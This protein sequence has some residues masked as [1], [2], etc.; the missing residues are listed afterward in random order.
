[1]KTRDSCHHVFADIRQF[2]RRKIAR[3]EALQGIGIG[4]ADAERFLFG[5]EAQKGAIP[6]YDTE[7]AII[8]ASRNAKSVETVAEC[9]KGQP[10]NAG[11]WL[12]CRSARQ[13]QLLQGPV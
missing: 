12:R 5:K 11:W 13:D 7:I 2:L 1:M 4:C 6:G 10:V 9:G 8:K 3:I